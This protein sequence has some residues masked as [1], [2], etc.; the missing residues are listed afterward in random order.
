MMHDPQTVA[1]LDQEDARLA[2][3]IRAHRWAV[4]YVG[5]GDDADEPRFGY[6][7]GL[8]GLGHPELVVVGLSPE[9]THGILEGV[10]GV[11]ADGRDLVAGELLAF[12]DRPDGLVVEELPN[13]GEVVLG[14]NRFYE[15]P[16]EYSVPAYQLAWAHRDG[17]FPWDEGY[18]RGPGF[19]PRPGTWHA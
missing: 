2:Q 1:W 13:P 16:A 8:S 5:E 7:I 19:Q 15:R 12:P 6:T 10:A 3:L 9:D 17:L 4:Q 18:A 14:A 11:V